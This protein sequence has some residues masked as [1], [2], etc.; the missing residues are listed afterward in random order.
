MRVH[1]RA[2]IRM[3]ASCVVYYP[4]QGA[5]HAQFRGTCLSMFY[6]PLQ[7]YSRYSKI[8]APLIYY[9]TMQIT[10]NEVQH[11]SARL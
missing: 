9:D 3:R 8:L 7:G 5:K 1:A 4:V 2:R 6:T 10:I 11:F